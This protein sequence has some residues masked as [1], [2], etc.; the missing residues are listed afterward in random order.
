[1]RYPYFAGREEN[2]NLPQRSEPPEVKTPLSFSPELSLMLSLLL[3]DN[4]DS[5]NITK[6]LKSIEP[7]LSGRDRESVARLLQYSEF[8]KTKPCRTKHGGDTDLMG[9]LQTLTG[10]SGS[11]DTGYIFEQMK[12]VFLAQ[13]QFSDF[14]QRLNRY[15]GS[16]NM[17]MADMMEMLAM[18]MPKDKMNGLNNISNMANMM[19]MFGNMKNFDPSMLMRMMG[20]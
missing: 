5:E 7:S 2:F 8:E 17:D 10:F 6:M 16:K 18:F 19:N 3:K 1:M 14:S 13:E 12:N 4:P 11:N 9:V 15:Q 20:R